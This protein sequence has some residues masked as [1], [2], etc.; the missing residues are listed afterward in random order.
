MFVLRTQTI[1]FQFST[2]DILK[3][4][5]ESRSYTMLYSMGDKFKICKKPNITKSDTCLKLILST[6]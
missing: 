2:V 1:N 5:C 4:E 6:D 3:L